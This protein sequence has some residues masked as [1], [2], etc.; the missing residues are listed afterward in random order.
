MLQRV[1]T[2]IQSIRLVDPV[3][4]KLFRD[5]DN[6]LSKILSSTEVNPFPSSTP[7]VKHVGVEEALKELNQLGL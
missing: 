2:D 7:N 3:R 1:N 5:V 4:E 6:T